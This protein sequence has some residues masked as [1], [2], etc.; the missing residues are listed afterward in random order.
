MKAW[1]LLVALS[2]L[3]LGGCLVTFKEPIP[4]GETA[5][6]H[7][8]GT[9]SGED[10]WGEQR[11]LEITR[12]PD[13]GYHALSWRKSLANRDKA[14]SYDFTVARHGHRW[15]LSVPAPK[16]LGG[17]FAFGGFELTDEDELVLY[18]LDIEQMQEALGKG[19]L[20]GRVVETEEGSGVLVASSLA[21]V[22]HF[23]DD[24]AN[25]D[26]FVEVA[27][28]GRASEQQDER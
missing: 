1:R 7:L 23:L 16:R 4:A 13:G 10:E 22:Y 24:P 27:R 3:L 9:W 14:R 15:Y 19:D 25:S 6:K 5:P 8:L 28:F 12:K 2:F 20:A 26:V 17:N 18:N 11:F 21:K